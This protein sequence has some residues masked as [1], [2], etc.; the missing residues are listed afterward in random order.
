MTPHCC[1]VCNGR[2]TVPAGFYSQGDYYSSVTYGMNQCRTCSGSG[3][4]WETDADRSAA[5]NPKSLSQLM[6]EAASCGSS[7][8]AYS[9]EGHAVW[10][11]EQP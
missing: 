9:P 4:L 6:E 7:P 5:T 11:E 1:P 8:P 2:G 10:R 3:V